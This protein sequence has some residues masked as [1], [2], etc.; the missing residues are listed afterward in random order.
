[1]NTPIDDQVVDFYYELFGKIFSAP[2]RARLSAE[3]RKRDTVVRQVEESAS[4]ASC[5][6]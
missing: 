2:F 3:R 6:L 4:A 5:S 1:M